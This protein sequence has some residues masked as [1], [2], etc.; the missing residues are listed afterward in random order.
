[1][2][3]HPGCAGGDVEGDFDGV[4]GFDDGRQVDF[5]SGREQRDGKSSLPPC[6][7]YRDVVAPFPQRGEV[8]ASSLRR[9][10]RTASYHTWGKWGEK[11]LALGLG[12]GREGTRRVG[13]G[14]SR[15]R[16]LHSHSSLPRALPGKD[17]AHPLRRVGI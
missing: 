11:R 8:V 15:C 1:M 7:I 3:T 9:G 5:D 12:F 17:V 16:S 10:V 4:I 13:G 2:T 14:G 6:N